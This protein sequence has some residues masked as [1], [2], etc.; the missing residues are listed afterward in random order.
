MTNSVTLNGNTYT[1]DASP[2][3]G[4]ANGGHRTRFIPA[5][6]DFV[7]DATAKINA[8]ATYVATALGYSNAAGTSATA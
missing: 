4:M 3:T 7:A 8:C 5:L 2:T 1:D 6:S